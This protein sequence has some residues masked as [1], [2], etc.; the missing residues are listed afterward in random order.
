MNRVIP[1]EHGETKAVKPRKKR[2]KRGIKPDTIR[3]EMEKIH[4]ALERLKQYI[5]I[6][7][8]EFSSGF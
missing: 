7:E 6:W 2:W 3:K 8:G 5:E 4:K 1:L